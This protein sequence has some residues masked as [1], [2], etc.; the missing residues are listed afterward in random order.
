MQLRCFSALENMNARQWNVR[1]KR[2]TEIETLKWSKEE[3]FH[4]GAKSL[5]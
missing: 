4:I 3:K 2:L 1:K 5:R